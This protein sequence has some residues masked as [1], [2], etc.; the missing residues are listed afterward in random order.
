MAKRGHLPN[1]V[2][3]RAARPGEITYGRR[4]S[5]RCFE[6]QSHI[7]QGSRVKPGMTWIIGIFAV[8]IKNLTYTAKLAFDCCPAACFGIKNVKKS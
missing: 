5:R 3:S 7:G 8:Y 6:R 4:L 1:P 2:N